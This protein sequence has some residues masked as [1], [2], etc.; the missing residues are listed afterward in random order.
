VKRLA[1]VCALLP[2]LARGAVVDLAAVPAD[3]GFVGRVL[4]H[5]GSG[6]AGVPVA[7][8][9]DCDGDGLGDY[10]FATMRATPF[11]RNGAGAAYLVFGDGSLGG[12]RDTGAPDARVLHVA[13][14]GREEAAGGALAMDDV[15]GD[16]IGDFLVARQNHRPD[17]GRIGAGALSIVVGG[18]ALRAHAATL[19]PLD[20]AGPPAG[21]LVTTI[22]GSEPLGRFGMWVRTG[23]VTGDGVADVVVGADQEN[24]A[25][26]VHAGAAYVL[27]GGAHLAAGGVLELASASLAGH[28]ARLVPG[29]DAEELHFG[30]TVQI[31]DLDGNGRG[32]VVIAGALARVGGSLVADGAPAGSAHSEGG[33]ED[34]TV[35]IVWDDAFA[36]AWPPGFELVA[37]GGPGSVTIVDGGAMNRV[38][39][40]ELLAGLDYD[41]DGRADLFVGDLFGERV[42]DGVLR[43]TGSGHV[44][45][46]AARLKGLA[47]DLDAPPPGVRTTAFLG[48]E[49]TALTADAGMHG[50]VDGDGFADLALS[51]P[52][53]SPL[54]REG[55]GVVYAFFGQLGGWPAVVDLAS[56]A[57]P[58][59][60]MVEVLGARGATPDSRGDL[61]AYSGASG[62]VDGDGLVDLLVNEMLGDGSSKAD[63]GNLVVIGGR[64]LA[65]YPCP[66]RPVRRCHAATGGAFRVR[67]VGDAARDRLQWRWASDDAEAAADLAGA[68]DPARVAGA[69]GLGLC[70]YDASGL[71]HARAVP[72]DESCAGATCWRHGRVTRFRAE[73]AMAGGLQRMAVRARARGTSLSAR[74]RGAALVPPPL[75]LAPPL[76]VQLVDG[77][78]CWESLFSQLR[79][80]RPGAL[81]AVI[82]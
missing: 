38:F 50:D 13:G 69:G 7:G 81:R 20:L 49:E 70:V 5:S 9:A 61:L 54:G 68:L 19:A 39:G 56:P 17:A 73:P 21:V 29:A 41:A 51:A 66:P 28:V 30:A 14:G 42:L 72:F 47:F 34:G 52:R 26:G 79:R 71:R 59:L 55:A 77:G 62:D 24:A 76:V 82:R 63:V 53:V 45:Y 11:G 23:D 46:D 36:G 57:P 48:V 80:N 33:S 40:E 4:G 35:F 32:E 74:G 2:A 65:G 8:G 75:P 44:L 60:R 22:V 67:D 37:G 6:T 10:A 58:P 25:D 1:L 12:T 18:A 43:R 16:G 3:A 78:R 64:L 27:R 31:G 15:T